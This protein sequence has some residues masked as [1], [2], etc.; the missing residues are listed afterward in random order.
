MTLD[1]VA[2]D[3]PMF[4]TE[5]TEAEVE[6]DE[7]SI[8]SEYGVISVA[9]GITFGT[10]NTSKTTN[11]TRAKLA[12]TMEER[13]ALEEANEELMNGMA[14][15]KKKMDMLVEFMKSQNLGE[16]ATKKLKEIAFPREEDEA[17]KVVELGKEGGNG[18]SGEEVI[19]P[20]TQ[21]GTSDIATPNITWPTRFKRTAQKS[22]RRI[23]PG[24]GNQRVVRS[25]ANPVVVN[26]NS[27]GNRGTHGTLEEVTMG[28]G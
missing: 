7:N 23:S 28:K 17:E 3:M 13:D 16:D 21:E 11:S 24:K 12:D 27:D 15:E 1:D 2:D 18:E 26:S 25:N 9:S 20:K 10:G 5:G 14:E 4:E 6:L 8:H 19:S 22:A